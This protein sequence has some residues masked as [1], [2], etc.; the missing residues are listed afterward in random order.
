MMHLLNNI[1]TEHSHTQYALKYFQGQEA[2]LQHVPIQTSDIKF[3]FPKTFAFAPCS[4]LQD[5]M[6]EFIPLPTE[7]H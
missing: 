7:K 4:P 1:P 5:M 2:H 6:N 3:Y